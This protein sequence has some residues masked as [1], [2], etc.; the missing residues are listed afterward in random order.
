MGSMAHLLVILQ[1]PSG[2]TWIGHF[3]QWFS[4]AVGLMLQ[5]CSMLPSTAP[6]YVSFWS[7]VMGPSEPDVGLSWVQWSSFDLVLLIQLDCR[8]Q[9]LCSSVIGPCSPI[10]FSWPRWYSLVLWLL[11][12]LHHGPLGCAW[13]YNGSSG[14]APPYSSRTIS[15]LALLLQHHCRPHAQSVHWAS[16][17]NHVME[18]AVQLCIG[19]LGT[20]P[21]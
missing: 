18:P 9:G 14:A 21:L 17:P 20:A 7:S 6:H 4:F 3:I 19:P 15:A 8:P 10:L 12:L 13:L 16:L 11:A 2:L 1:A 5:L